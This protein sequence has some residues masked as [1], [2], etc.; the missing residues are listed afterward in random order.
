MASKKAISATVDSGLVKWIDEQI[1]S[2]PKYRNRSHLIEIAIKAFIDSQPHGSQILDTQN[3][4]PDTKKNVQK[5]DASNNNEN[6]H[7]KKPGKKR[8]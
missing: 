7:E 5:K 6:A 8:R 4:I 1:N 3:Q 2:S